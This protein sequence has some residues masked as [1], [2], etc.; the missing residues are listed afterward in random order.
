MHAILPGKPRL[1]STLVGLLVLLLFNDG[2]VASPVR[3]EEP[4][5]PNFRRPADDAEL[6]Y[7][8]E[9]MVWYHRFSH[10]EIAAATGLDEPTIAAALARFDIR[11][12]GRPARRDGDPL[13]V[14]PYPGGRHPRIG[15]LEGA[16][17]PQRE[18]KVSVFTPWDP[19]SYVV[20]DV[21][22]AIRWQEGILYLAHTHVDTAWTLKNVE[23]EPLEWQRHDDG[24]YELR[25]E[26]PNGVS[27]GTIVTPRPDSVRMEMWLTNG[28]DETLE[29]LNVQNCIMLKGAEGF[30]QQSNENK[31]FEGAYATCH[32]P[33]GRRW[34]ITAWTP[35]Q[36]TWANERCPCLHSDP[37]FPDCPPGE[38]RRLKGWLSF[39]EGDDIQSEIRRI[40]A[41]GW[42]D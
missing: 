34:I 20:A 10:E 11:P 39:Y 37:R 35:N 30:T 36:R 4:E 19:S 31:V 8:L 26:L 29:N 22:E 2:F 32:S 21:P 6:R 41:T 15:F 27:F 38:T 25:R 17:R 42:D 14:L 7:W 40:E 13:E 16:I 33:D 3:G 5:A 23:L 24:R 28:S 18:T 9:N 1:P 12:D